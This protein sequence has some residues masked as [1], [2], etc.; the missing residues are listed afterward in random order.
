[1]KIYLV[2]GA[3]R[4]K[5]MGIEPKD[6]DWV[7]VGATAQD[8]LD[9]GFTQVGSFFPVFLHPETGEE[10]A[11]ARSER[12][13]GSGYLDFECVTEGVT[14]EEDLKRRDLTINAIAMDEEGNVI[15]PY[16]GREDLDNRVLRHVSEAFAEDPVRILRIGRFLARYGA[17]W[18][19]H[20]ETVR[21]A[22]SMVDK[23]MLDSLTPER[24]WKEFSRGLMEKF[25][26][27][28]VRWFQKLK[29]FSLPSFAD[30]SGIYNGQISCLT[31]SCSRQSSLSLAVKFAL[32][33]ARS[34]QG[35][36][37]KASCIPLDIR[38]VA[39]GLYHTR[40]ANYIEYMQW[41][42]D[43]KFQFLK[44]V[45]PR[46]EML[47]NQIFEAMAIEDSASA[48]A[49]ERDYSTLLSVD[50]KA[51]TQ[52]MP[53]GPQVG[54]AIMKAQYEALKAAYR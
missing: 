53:P 25:P 44:E 46:R 10:Y 51:I 19:V 15:D 47:R 31:D 34:W 49:I 11:L 54:Q 7:V 17:G 12:S 50:T 26:F 43:Q 45:L 4:D 27:L 41:P 35:S 13:T 22:F 48:F 32:V 23:G 18:S 37:A 36:E 16:N 21:L 40:G 20:Q 39:Q 42:L 3:V 9:K 8:M 38:E 30:Y 29:L 24:V 2:G 52:S 6:R 5:L 28:M 1:M 33:F 14:L